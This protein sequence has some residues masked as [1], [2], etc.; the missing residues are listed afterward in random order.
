M[1]KETHV[2]ILRHLRNA[3]RRKPPEKWSTYSLFLLYDNAAAR[4]LVLVKDFLARNN[5]TT[6]DH[7][8]YSADLPA[9]DVYLFPRLKS[10]LNGRHFCDATDTIENEMEEQKRF[11]QNGF[12]NCF[13]H[14]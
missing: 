14:L 1:N 12:Q 5:V 3:V 8:P 2:D 4:R 13:Q 10:A 9:A 7:P 6:L 11:S